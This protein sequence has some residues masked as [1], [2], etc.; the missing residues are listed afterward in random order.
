MKISGV[1]LAA[2]KGT[3]MKSSLPKVLQPVLG[4]PMIYY[5]QE[6]L[7]NLEN[8]YVITGYESELVS[9]HIFDGYKI[10]EQKEQ[11]GTGH[12][13]VTLLESKEF[14]S[15][16]SD[17][18]IIIPGDVP[19]ID[20]TELDKLVQEVVKKDSPIGLISAEVKNPSGYGRIVRDEDK[21]KKITEEADANDE[22]RSISEINSGIYCVNKE[23]LISNIKNIKSDNVQNEFYLTDLIEIVFQNNQDT[24]IVQVIEDTIKGVNSMSQ[25]NDVEDTLKAKL[26]SSHMENGVYFQD[27][28]TT[29]IDETVKIHSGSKI[30]ANC[31]LTGNTE[32]KE[33]C[34]IGPNSLINDSTIGEGSKVLYS[35]VDGS[36]IESNGQIGPY[37]HLRT[38][39][40][41]GDNVKVGA[42]AE[43]KNSKIS[44][45][46]K[47]PHLAY[48]GDA[49]L[50]EGV[51]FSAGAITVNYDG[52]E[53][54]KTEIKKGAFVGSD[55]MLVAPVTIG[56][57]AMVGA[58][59]VITKDVPPK[60]LGIERNQQK[61]IDGY[62]DRKKSSKDKK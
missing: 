46:S 10:V 30:F 7:S 37:A 36:D 43:T 14:K 48:V 9:S 44:K 4:K 47:V 57:G 59:S 26:I 13:V 62:M 2:G 12:A 11:L 29:Y 25:L 58:G 39:S 54:H 55:A 16:K 34:D 19:L 38:G 61:N 53:K 51:N 23:F 41:L 20:K 1:I 31:H 8:K 27:P 56:E 17:Y 40:T 32:I 18:L 22:E 60:S 3:R 33:N 42:F 52:K 45:D 21:V 50:E 5:A 24:V 35:V 49:E 28:S 15:D 6:S